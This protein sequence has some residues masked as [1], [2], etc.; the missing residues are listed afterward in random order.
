IVKLK[1]KRYTTTYK[2]C[3]RLPSFWD[4]TQHNLGMIELLLVILNIRMKK[5]ISPAFTAEPHCL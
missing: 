2:Q 3:W 5:E 1:G 4:S